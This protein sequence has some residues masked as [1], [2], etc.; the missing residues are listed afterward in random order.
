MTAEPGTHT[1]EVSIIV[2]AY[3][4]QDTIEDVVLR[5]LALPLDMEIIVVDDGSTDSTPSI[6]ARYA[7]RVTVVKNPDPGG[8]GKAIRAGLKIATGRVVVIQDADL[9]YRPEEL[10]LV[11]D[12]IVAGAASVV[13]GSRFSKGM[14]PS[15]ALPNKVVNVLLALMTRVLYG[16]WITDEATCYKAVRRDLLGRMD[17]VC[18]R[19]EFCPEV[20]AK[21]SRL[22]EK[23]VEVPISYE[24]RSVKAGKKIRW[25]DGVEAIWTLL[26]YRFWKPGGN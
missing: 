19:F 24:P 26:R 12:P 4:E 7:A 8:K 2:P 10:H 1:P 20:T 5:L 3:N 17:L 9:E 21:V 18:E 6:L 13:Y 15:M 25:T 22:G 16:Q 23:I 14:H 11:T